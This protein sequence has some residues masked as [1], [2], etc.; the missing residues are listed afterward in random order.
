[1]ALH[2]VI[3]GGGA[4][5][6]FAALTAAEAA[7]AATVTILERSPKL[8]S[9]VRISGGGRCN[10]THHCFDPKT[11]AGHYPRGSRELRAAFHR[12]QPTDMIRWLEARSV[13]VKTEA[14]G[15]IF[16]TTDRSQTI[17]DCFLGEAH[18][19]GIRI[20]KGLGLKGF[21]RES[22][23]SFAL[24]LTDGTFRRA[25]R[26]CLAAGS[27]KASPLLPLLE[28]TGHPIEAPV[29]SLFAFNMADKRLLGLAGLSLPEIHVWLAED[30]RSRQ[31]GPALITHRGL[32]GPAILRLSAWEARRLQRS[33]YHCP[34]RIN[35]LGGMTAPQLEEAV[36]E[37]RRHC[38]A[39]R[40]RQ[41]ALAPVPRRLWERLA[42]EAG[43]SDTQTW[44]QLGKPARARLIDELTEGQFTV[45]GKTTNKE[46]FVTAGGVGLRAVDFRTMQ[47][48]H[49]P[50][51]FFA[52]ECLD[53]DGITGGFNFQAAWTT[54]HIAGLGLVKA[55][56]RTPAAPVPA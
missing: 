8:L 19:Y 15:R 46:E 4:A 54:G 26:I 1:M 9:K 24:E 13:T 32:S 53:I 7:P 42:G 10:V 16:P 17:I 30:K 6:F 2:I 52:G 33:Q 3:V 55:T 51:L 45:E 31:S 18:A 38:G 22:D 39:K 20:E 25:D 36:K 23:G 37:R 49:L 34:I 14:D 43:I 44:A 40:I 35:W 41:D 12:W 11:L 29:P 47:S 21:A 48:K 56:N 28:A 27:L 50:G 5:G